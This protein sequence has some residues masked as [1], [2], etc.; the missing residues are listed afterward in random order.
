MLS[1]RGVSKQL[2]STRALAGIDLELCAGQTAVLIGISGSGKSTVLRLIIGLVAP[3][4]GE[5]WF[6]GQRV[7]GKDALLLRRRMGYVIQDGGLFPHLTAFENVA[8]M[9]RYLRWPESRVRERVQSLRELTRLPDSVLQRYPTQLS[10]G[11]R[12]RVSLM[13][14]LVLDPDVLL[15]DEPLAAL[16]PITRADLQ[17][18][19]RAIFRTLG[20]TVL[21]VTHDLAEAAFFSDFVALMREGEIVQRGSLRD[22]I[23]HPADDFVRRFVSAQRGAFAAYEEQRS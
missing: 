21:L 1:L 6:A 9:P 8:L 7:G 19:L 4:A 22:L 17:H 11:Q 15:L 5:V 10:G 20:K 16:D 3:D 18:E 12:Q 14:A 13:R 2:G 23:E